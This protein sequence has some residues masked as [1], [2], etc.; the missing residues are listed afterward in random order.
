MQVTGEKV[1]DPKFP[2]NPSTKD[3]FQVKK[4]FS[5]CV[6]PQKR[7]R[8]ALDIEKTLLDIYNLLNKKA[9]KNKP[10]K[11]T[12]EIM[13]EVLEVNTYEEANITPY[14]LFSKTKDSLDIKFYFPKFVRYP[15]WEF[16]D[17][18]LLE[19]TTEQI[20][21]G[22]ISIPEGVQ[23]VSAPVKDSLITHFKIV[24]E[25]LNTLTNQ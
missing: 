9:P 2:G 14:D 18:H 16:V 12:K 23:A 19:S 11:K 6:L 7:K 15:G 10:R 17:L 22:Q 1:K 25:T 5:L 8:E 20:R 3:S 21:T 24:Y 4:Q 13:H